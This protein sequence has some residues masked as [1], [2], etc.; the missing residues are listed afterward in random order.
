VRGGMSGSH[1]FGGRR[2]Q[3]KQRKAGMRLRCTGMSGRRAEHVRRIHQ[4]AGA[5][6][7]LV[8]ACGAL[9]PGRSFLRKKSE[10]VCEMFFDEPADVE[11]QGLQK[12]KMMPTSKVPSIHHQ[13]VPSQSVNG[14][15][16]RS[17][18]SALWFL[19]SISH[20]GLSTSLRPP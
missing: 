15:C 12:E 4:S 18:A 1:R 20:S 2:R 9:M 6:P 19:S 14:G 16:D 10:L 11:Q 13:R 3:S 17:T 7:L 8:T 5:D